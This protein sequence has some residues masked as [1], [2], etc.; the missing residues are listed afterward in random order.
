MAPSLKGAFLPLLAGT[1]LLKRRLLHQ[2]V[3]PPSFRKYFNAYSKPNQALSPP[4]VRATLIQ[5]TAA[6]NSTDP[7]PFYPGLATPLLQSRIAALLQHAREVHPGAIPPSRGARRCSQ[8][9]S[10]KPRVPQEGL[11]CLP[12]PLNGSGSKQVRTADEARA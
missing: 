2:H 9:C 3:R 10:A 5:R 8:S 6:Q 4:P 12:C 11:R 1:A 7:G